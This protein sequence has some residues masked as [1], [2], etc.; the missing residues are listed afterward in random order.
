MP[1]ELVCFNPECRARYGIDEVLYQCSLCGALLEVENDFQGIKPKELQQCWDQRRL[2]RAP[3]DVSGVWRFREMLPFADPTHIVSLREAILLSWTC[4]APR[5]MG[6]W[7]T[8]SASTR[9]TTLRR[10]SKT[11]A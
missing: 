4:L 1:A 11:T 10:R 5:N 9:V 3:L 8:S 7:R 2:S 6:G